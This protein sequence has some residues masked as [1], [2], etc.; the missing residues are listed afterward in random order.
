MAAA[1]KLAM[2]VM[3][4]LRLCNDGPARRAWR[5]ADLM[6]L[7]AYCEDHRITPDDLAAAAG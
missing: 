7:I 2:S 5:R 1:L 6:R 3:A 4:T